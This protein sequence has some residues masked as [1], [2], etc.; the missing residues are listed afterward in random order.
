[1]TTLPKAA[2]DAAAHVLQNIEVRDTDTFHREAAEAA[3]LA[4]L[5]HLGEPNCWRIDET[6][7][8]GSI[9]WRTVEHQH[10]AFQIAAE[11]VHPVSVYPLYLAPGSAAPAIK[12]LEWTQLPRNN[13]GEWWVTKTPLGN[14]EV[15]A[16]RCNGHEFRG[17]GNPPFCSRVG[18]S[19]AEIKSAFEADYEARI[20][21]ALVDAPAT[22]MPSALSVED[23]WNDLLDKDD[24]TSPAEY[25]DM[26]LITMQELAGYMTADA[27]EPAAGLKQMAEEML[28]DTNAAM[29]AASSR[30]RLHPLTGDPVKG[31]MA[32]ALREAITK[33]ENDRT[34]WTKQWCEWLIDARDALAIS[35]R[36]ASHG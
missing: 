27:Q 8:G 17:R 19:T 14:Y 35:E 20:R 7:T 4:A 16:E 11:S 25:P 24:R 31:Q 32:K 12:P 29:L 5:P 1:M 18:D 23:A 26:C 2:I 10:H 34:L 28:R 33:V 6:V 15:F 21:S 3:I 13:G 36:E 30:A 9:Q 22:P